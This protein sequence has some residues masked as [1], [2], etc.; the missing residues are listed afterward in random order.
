M[1]FKRGEY[2][3]KDNWN[4]KDDRINNVTLHR[5]VKRHKTR[6]ELCQRC[7]ER[8]PR[9]LA[10]ITGIYDRNL[11]NWEYMCKKCHVRFDNLIEKNLEPY[12]IKPKDLSHNICFICK[13]DETYIRKRDN[14]PGWCYIDNKPVCGRCYPKEMRRRKSLSPVGV[15]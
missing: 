14:R 9:D 2:V 5:Y 7:K 1:I 11:D 10:N 12:Y 8:P 13:S 6:P 3:G 4:W 15:V